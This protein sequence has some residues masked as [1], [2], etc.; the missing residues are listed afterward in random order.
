MNLASTGP[1]SR[2]EPEQNFR[3]RGPVRATRALT[4][5]EGFYWAYLGI[6]EKLEKKMETTI[7]YWGNIGKMEKKM[8]TT[9]V[10]WGNVGVGIMEK[11]ME[12][13]IVY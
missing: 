2:A 8:E 4:A 1:Q 3:W 7:V 6:M 11:E 12:T 5:L 9:I 10:Y 13:T